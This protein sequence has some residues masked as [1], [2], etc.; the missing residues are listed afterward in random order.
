[1]DDEKELVRGQLFLKP[2]S[3][4]E[5]RSKKPMAALLVQRRSPCLRFENAAT[6][7]RDVQD[8]A[9]GGGPSQG[10]DTFK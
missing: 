10:E 5:I 2:R 1:M 9:A 3:P 8:L 7:N 4:H 6:S